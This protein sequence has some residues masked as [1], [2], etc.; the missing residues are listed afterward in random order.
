MDSIE[1]TP[2]KVGGLLVEIDEVRRIVVL[3]KKLEIE[4]NATADLLIELAKSWLNGAGKG[5][6]PLDFPLLKAAEL[7][8]RFDLDGE[9]AVRRRILNARNLMAKRFA[10][11]GMDVSLTQHL[12]ENIP[13]LGYRLS[14]DRVTVRRRKAKD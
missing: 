1:P 12:I 6:S 13:W 14:P 4:R 5:L 7:A 10:T 11:C 3:D 2:E 9:E 8:K